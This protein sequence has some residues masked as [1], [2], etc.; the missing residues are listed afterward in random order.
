MPYNWWTNQIYRQHVDLSESTIENGCMNA[1]AHLLKVTA[2]LL[3]LNHIWTNCITISLCQCMPKKKKTNKNNWEISCG[4][5]AVA[6]PYH[7]TRFDGLIIIHS[8]TRDNSYEHKLKNLYKSRVVFLSFIFLF[9][10]CVHL[11]ELCDSP[12][13]ILIISFIFDSTAQYS[14]H[15]HTRRPYK[16]SG[17]TNNLSRSKVCKQLSTRYS[18]LYWR[19]NVRMHTYSTIITVANDSYIRLLLNFNYYTHFRTHITHVE[20]HVWETKWL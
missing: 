8:Y 12:C 20:K 3:T 10:W 17:D 18:F 13:T 14:T 7:Y 4:E 2:I 6:I 1:G 15:A 19:D 16:L 11:C 5:K 9:K